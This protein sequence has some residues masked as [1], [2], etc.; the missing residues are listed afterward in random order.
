VPFW[1]FF[2]LKFWTIHFVLEWC[3]SFIAEFKIWM[4]GLFS[5][6][7]NFCFTLYFPEYLILGCRS[8]WMNPSIM[9]LLTM[10]QTLQAQ[11][12][13]SWMW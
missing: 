5:L 1:K 10:N 2:G 4:M 6:Q 11:R 13:S 9:A 12:Q 7:L 8:F 3:L